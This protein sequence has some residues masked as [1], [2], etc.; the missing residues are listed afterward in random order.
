[1]ETGTP[2]ANTASRMEEV[3]EGEGGILL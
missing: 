1:M 2:P 3:R